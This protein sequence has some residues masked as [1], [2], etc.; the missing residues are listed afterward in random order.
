MLNEELLNILR[1]RLVYISGEEIS[2]N[3]GIS[4]TAIW[5]HIQ[6]LRSLG[7]DITAVPNLG[8]KLLSIPDRLFPWEINYTLKNRLIGKNIYYYE[9]LSSTMDKAMDLALNK[10]LEGTLVIAEGQTKGRGRMGRYWLSPKYKGIYFSLIIRPKIL[11]Q[12]APVFT[13]ISAVAICDGLKQHLGVEA[14]IKWPNDILLQNR[15]IGGIL[16]ELNAEMDVVH[17]IIIGVG[18]NVNNKKNTLPHH[19]GS[20]MEIIGA[21][22]SRLSILLSILSCFEDRYLQFQKHGIE[23]VLDVWRNFSITLGR[24]VRLNIG[25]QR[26]GLVGE[27]VDIDRDGSLLIRQDSG[28]VK[29]VTAGDIIHCKQ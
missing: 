6:E 5:K 28:L 15:K 4:R 2:N 12:Q 27:A 9:S 7:Y 11:L 17:A 16:T 23:R 14:R 22:I 8:Y 21:E 26:F 19:A 18:I 3:L 24:R 25:K 13:L 10:A 20:L 29:K 1:K